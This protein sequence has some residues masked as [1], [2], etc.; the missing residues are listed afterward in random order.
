[1]HGSACQQFHGVLCQLIKDLVPCSWW[2]NI[3]ILLQHFAINPVQQHIG[4]PY[5]IL[6]VQPSMYSGNRYT[7]NSMLH[8]VHH[9]DCVLNS[10]AHLTMWN[11]K[12][13]ECA[14]IKD[15]VI[16]DVT[17]TGKLFAFEDSAR[18]APDR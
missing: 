9:G 12:S 5:T 18:L 17:T 15:D 4:C 7:W 10:Q 3:C 1:M 16:D 6:T 11:T 13:P 14:I 8:V 2:W